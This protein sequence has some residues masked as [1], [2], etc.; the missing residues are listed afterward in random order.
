MVFREDYQGNLLDALREIHPLHNAQVVEFGAGTGR[1]TRLLLLHVALICAFDQSAAMLNVAHRTLTPL[2]EHWRLAVAD[3]ANLPVSDNSAD[4]AIEGW[5][6][7]H[8]TGWHRDRWQTVLDSYLAE[9]RR[10]VKPGG[11]MIL[12]ETMGT[13]RESPQP[14]NDALA[15]MYAYLQTIHQFAYRW[16]RTD[17]LF[18]SVQEA[19]QLT[20]FFFGDDLAERVIREGLTILPECTGIWWKSNP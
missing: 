12:I 8:V 19:D 18:E 4:V 16:I 6:F 1:L 7:G 9:M 11:A 17:Y 20:R 2:G 5:S 13:G 10:V 3:N 14:P 15:E